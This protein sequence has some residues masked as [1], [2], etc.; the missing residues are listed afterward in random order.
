M[1]STKITI[2][3]NCDNS[4]RKK[5]LADFNT[6][7]ATDDLDTLSKAFSDDIRWEMVGDSVIEGKEAAIELLKEMNGFMRELH[8]KSVITHG[9]LAAVDGTMMLED[10]KTYAFCDTYRFVSVGK[11]LIKEIR[12]YVIEI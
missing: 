2:P 6:A 4:P 12:S 9:P 5:F 3:E 10:G 7:F 1:S 11:N 8:I